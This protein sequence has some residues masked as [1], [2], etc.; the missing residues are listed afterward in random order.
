MHPDRPQ[1]LKALSIIEMRG[2]Q[3]SEN[4][5]VVSPLG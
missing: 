3:I 1:A 4:E 5:N 2:T